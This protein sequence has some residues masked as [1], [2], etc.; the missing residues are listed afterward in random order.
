MDNL[1]RKLL[2]AEKRKHE[3]SLSHIEHIKNQLFPNGGLQER[4]ENIALFYVAY[5]QRLIDD[6]IDKFEPL[7]FKFAV[8]VE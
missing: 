8:L 3:V 4:S 6:L 1:E 7:E 5:G 2:K